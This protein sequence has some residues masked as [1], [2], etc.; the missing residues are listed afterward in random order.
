MSFR[1]SGVNSFFSMHEF[2]SGLQWLGILKLIMERFP[3][4][5]EETDSVEAVELWSLHGIGSTADRIGIS[6]YSNEFHS[7]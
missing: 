6:S 2:V 3:D 4:E 1:L 5:Q 7:T